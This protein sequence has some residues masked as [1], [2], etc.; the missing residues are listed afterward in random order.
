[1]LKTP[2]RQLKAHVGAVHVVHYNANGQYCL[3]G[4]QDRSIILWNPNTGAKIKSYE[5]HGWEVLDIAISFDNAKFASVG[6]DKA[7][8]SLFPLWLVSELALRG[9]EY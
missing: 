2:V 9:L 4:G 6:G 1:M 3:S 7:V 8:Y 5:A